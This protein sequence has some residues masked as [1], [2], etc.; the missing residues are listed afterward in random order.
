MDKGGPYA[1]NLSFIF[2][3]QA[4]KPSCYYMTPN[5]TDPW[6]EASSNDK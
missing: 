1:T 3:R 2:D 6:T 4:A 5:H